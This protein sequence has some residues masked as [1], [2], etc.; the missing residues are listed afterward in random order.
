MSNEKKTSNQNNTSTIVDNPY[1]KIDLPYGIQTIIRSKDSMKTVLLPKILKKLMKD[2]NL[3]TR[4]LAK[5]CQLPLS[6]LSSYMSDVKAS[7]N[8]AHLEC[9]AN[10]FKVSIDYLLFGKTKQDGLSTLPTELLYQG[11]IKIK[12]EK[13][14]PT[15]DNDNKDPEE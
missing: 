4:Q 7:Y 6:T 9:L 10:Y 2:N 14:I 15:N 13:A 1:T 3:S 8:P 12:V 5:K 11:W